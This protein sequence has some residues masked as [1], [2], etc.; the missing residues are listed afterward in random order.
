MLANCNLQKLETLFILE[1][2]QCQKFVMS[3]YLTGHPIST[4]NAKSPISASKKPAAPNIKHP[5][6]TRS[7]QHLFQSRNPTFYFGCY[8]LYHVFGNLNGCHLR[9]EYADDHVQFQDFFKQITCF[10]KGVVISKKIAWRYIDTH[11]LHFFMLVRISKMAN[12]LIQ[13]LPCILLFMY[14]LIF[15]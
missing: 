1:S 12:P 8:H 15:L 2:T 5:S 4:P 9:N 7:S 3:A 6:R 11:N 10:K 13:I 14:L